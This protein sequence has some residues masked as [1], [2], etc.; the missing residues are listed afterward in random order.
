[1]DRKTV[2]EV[3][4]LIKAAPGQMTAN[5]NE[6]AVALRRANPQVEVRNKVISGLSGRKMYTNI[7]WVFRPEDLW[8]LGEIGYSKNVDGVDEWTINSPCIENKRYKENHD[9]YHTLRSSDLNNAVRIACAMFRPFSKEE[10]AKQT[11]HYCR[12]SFQARLLTRAKGF[13]D[14]LVIS[15]KAIIDEIENYLVMGKIE[16]FVTPQFQHLV[17]NY[18]E[19]KEAYDKEKNRRAVVYYVVLVQ[20][21][22]HMLTVAN[23]RDL[24]FTLN[25]EKQIM[26]QADLPYDM[27]AKIAA[28]MLNEPTVYTAGLGV[29]LDNFHF[30]VEGD[31]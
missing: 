29:R 9:L 19:R 16:Q 17:R 11:M 20:D 3:L 21:Y 27:Q 4:A 15:K 13:E 30:W 26:K 2:R 7:A 1:M 12:D 14:L 6:F 8:V 25:G 10:E 23:V 24:P 18:R 31:E 5:L 22:A 28:L